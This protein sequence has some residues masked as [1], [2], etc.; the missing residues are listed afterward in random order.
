MGNFLVQS[1]Y[2]G[3]GIVINPCTTDRRYWQNHVDY[4]LTINASLPLQKPSEATILSD[5]KYS[6]SALNSGNGLPIIYIDFT[7]Y[8]LKYET[9]IVEKSMQTK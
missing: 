3:Y 4:I 9:F 5:M 7:V 8:T 6:I 1:K 2:A